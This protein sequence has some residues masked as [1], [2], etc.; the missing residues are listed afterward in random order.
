M[1]RIQSFKNV[2][3]LFWGISEIL[4]SPAD[5]F[6]LRTHRQQ[7]GPAGFFMDN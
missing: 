5:L 6:Q 4:A 3:W 2:D 7:Q 1:L